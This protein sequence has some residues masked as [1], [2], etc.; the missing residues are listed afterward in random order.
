MR[1][2]FSAKESNPLSPAPLGVQ[3]DVLRGLLALVGQFLPI[4]TLQ[5][6]RRPHLDSAPS[7][8]FH[9]DRTAYSNRPTLCQAPSAPGFC[10]SHPLPRTRST[11][12]LLVL[13]LGPSLAFSLDIMSSETRLLHL[14]FGIRGSC[15][16]CLQHPFSSGPCAELWL[17]DQSMWRGTVSV[18]VSPS[19]SRLNDSPTERKKERERKNIETDRQVT[20][21]PQPLLWSECVLPNLHVGTQASS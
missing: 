16:M 20:S 17:S 18:W 1:R 3:L 13:C 15:C 6:P 8:R 10:T 7:T 21:S 11:P 9:P 19:Q 4:G 12:C 2:V 5:T 14:H